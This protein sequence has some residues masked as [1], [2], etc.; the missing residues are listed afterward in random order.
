MFPVFFPQGS[1][2]PIRYL[3]L[4]PLDPVPCDI[5]IARAQTP[6]DVM[7]LA[8]EVGILESE[9]G[10]CMCL[11]VCLCVF[12]YLCVRIMSILCTCVTVLKGIYIHSILCVSCQCQ[13]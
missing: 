3:P 12:A 6:K 9:V 11:S 2:W 5:V 1:H 7:E 4:A 8:R 13:L 10:T